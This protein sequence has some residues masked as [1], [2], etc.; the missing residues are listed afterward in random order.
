MAVKILEEGKVSSSS[1]FRKVI[2]AKAGRVD[3]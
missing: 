1:C 2:M 3:F